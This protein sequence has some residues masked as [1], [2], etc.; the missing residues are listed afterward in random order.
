MYNQAAHTWIEIQ[1]VPAESDEFQC[2]ASFTD[3][4]IIDVCGW[5]S[6]KS[7]KCIIA[8]GTPSGGTL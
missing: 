8:Q 6:K 7:Q 3:K 4:K 5:V 2:M 1:A